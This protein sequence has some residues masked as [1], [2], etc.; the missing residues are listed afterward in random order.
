MT[1]LKKI[2]AFLLLA[3]CCTS[4]AVAETVPPAALTI[5]AVGD[6]MMGTDF[7]ENDLPPDDGRELFTE[8]R[9]FLQQADIAFG[10]LEGTLCD[11]GVCAKNIDS[12]NVYA[13]RTPTAFASNLA[14]AGFKAL[15]LANNTH[16]HLILESTES[17]PPSGP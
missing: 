13:F 1:A 14:A 7:P 5:A 16:M 12:P 3:V 17:G 9:V 11:G 15:S 8:V 4:H 2:C 6:I 10:N